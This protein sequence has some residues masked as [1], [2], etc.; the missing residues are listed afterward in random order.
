MLGYGSKRSDFYKSWYITISEIVCCQLK[1]V[2][3]GIEFVANR[4]FLLNEV[5]PTMLC[6]G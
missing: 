3:S 2:L 4:S 5:V 6:S 1:I